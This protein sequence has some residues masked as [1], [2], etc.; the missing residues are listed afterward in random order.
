MMRAVVLIVVMV[1]PSAIVWAMN[2]PNWGLIAAV[3]LGVAWVIVLSCCMLSGDISEE[4]LK[5]YRC[6]H[7]KTYYCPICQVD[8]PK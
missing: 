4:E 5:R 8:L 6:S 2:W 3:L 1:T 7:G